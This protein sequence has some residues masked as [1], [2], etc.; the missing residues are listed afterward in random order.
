MTQIAQV[1]QRTKNLRLRFNTLSLAE[2]RNLHVGAQTWSHSCADWIGLALPVQQGVCLVVCHARHWDAGE[3]LKGAESQLFV[4]PRWLFLSLILQQI[5]HCSEMLHLAGM[6]EGSSVG[7]PVRVQ[8][9]LPREKC[10]FFSFID[11]IDWFLLTYVIVKRI[12][13][14]LICPR[15]LPPF[16]HWLLEVPI[17]RPHNPEQV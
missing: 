14:H 6:R 3:D 10:F 13:W 9:A 15:C 16:V 1:E 11:M 17:L 5:R 2:T 12:F 4:A 8:P 7:S